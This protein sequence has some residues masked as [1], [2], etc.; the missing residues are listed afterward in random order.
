[1]A[2]MLLAGGTL[3]KHF[4]NILNVLTE[5]NCLFVVT[6]LVFDLFLKKMVI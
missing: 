1:M 5:L 2:F 3:L 6:T 4:D